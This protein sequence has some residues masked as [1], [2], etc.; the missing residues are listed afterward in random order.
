MTLNDL[1]VNFSH[2]DRHSLLSDWRWLIG[3]DRHPILLAAAGDAFVQD[4]TDG[5][6]HML[7]VGTGSLH[8]VAD[9]ESD[10]RTLLT[11]KQFVLDHL[12]VPM[13]GDLRRA[14][15]VLGP[16]QIYSF[17]TPPVLGGE[18]VM[19]NVEIADIEVHFS[20]NGQIHEQV[21]ALPPGTPIDRIHVG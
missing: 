10:F 14:G 15:H 6:I 17:K 9:S 11:K 4:A 20:T 5:S 19:S 8:L 3:P 18:Y 2:L 7:D 13:V 12:T 1:T 21:A 16:G